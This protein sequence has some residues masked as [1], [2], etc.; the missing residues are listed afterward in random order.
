[1]W[2]VLLDPIKGSEQAGHRP[3][4]IV[5]PESMNE[6]LDT[7]IVVP[8]SSQKRDWPTRVDIEFLDVTGQALCEQIRTVSKKRLTK[9]LGHLPIKDI[10]QVK[11]VLK[12][13]LIE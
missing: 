4:I 5:S 8:L 3:C 10:L 11:L 1:M 2:Q 13:M 9:K 6:Q 7:I 12:Q